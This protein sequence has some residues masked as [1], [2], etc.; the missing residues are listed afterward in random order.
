MH[1][2]LP[3]SWQ[4]E[5]REK[6]LAEPEEKRPERVDDEYLVSLHNADIDATEIEETIEIQHF[7][8][9]L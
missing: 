8:H 7:C 4:Q 1:D 6:L 5:L 2:A 9:G 3:S